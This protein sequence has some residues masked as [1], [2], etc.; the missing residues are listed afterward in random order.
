MK[1][2]I[3]LSAIGIFSLSSFSANRETSKTLFKNQTWKYTCADGTTGTFN[4][5]GCTQSEAQT[6]ANDK[7]R[8]N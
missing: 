3:L 2:L 5:Y 1:K 7:C 8:K 4:C 6:I